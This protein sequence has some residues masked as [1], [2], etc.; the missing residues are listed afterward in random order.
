[1]LDE[2]G[3]AVTHELGH[4]IRVGEK[5]CCRS[6]DRIDK[7]FRQ[8]RRKLAHEISILRL[9]RSLRVIENFITEAIPT[10]KHAQ[11]K[12]EAKKK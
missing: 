2:E 9:V 10:R 11:M 3:Q 12:L 4:E 8:G 7:I 5:R 6:E 1:M